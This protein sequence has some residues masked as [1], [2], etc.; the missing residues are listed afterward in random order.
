MEHVINI[1]LHVCPVAILFWLNCKSVYSYWQNERK[2]L[3]VEVTNNNMLHSSVGSSCTVCVD[4]VYI[5]DILCVYIV[6]IILC[7][8]IVDI[9][10][11][12]YII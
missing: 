7:V 3:N 8:Y 4:I 10:L 11:C 2:L 6:D 5:V 12:V 1:A 9:I